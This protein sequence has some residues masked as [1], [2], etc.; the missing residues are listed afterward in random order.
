M[1]LSRVPRHICVC[2]LRHCGDDCHCKVRHVLD[3]HTQFDCFEGETYNGEDCSRRQTKKAFVLPKYL[4][5]PLCMK[6]H[7]LN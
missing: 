6:S 5:A 1:W 4:V 2:K 3:S 7:H